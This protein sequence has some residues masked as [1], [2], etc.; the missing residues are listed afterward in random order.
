MNLEIDGEKLIVPLCSCGRCIVKRERT[1]LNPLFPYNKKLGSTYLK[2]YDQKESLLSP[3]YFNRSKRNCFD[4][5]YKEHLPAGL[6]SRMKYDFKPFKIVLE[7]NKSPVKNLESIPFWGKSSYN[8]FFPN[9]GSPT[10]G[11]TEKV[12]LPRI[13]VPLRG[14]SNYLDNY[15]RYED[16]VYKNRDP[17]I[18][19]KASINFKGQ[20]SPDTTLRDTYKP[21]DYSQKH[22]FSP[23]KVKKAEKEKTALIPANYSNDNFKSTYE[24]FFSEKPK[25]CELATYLKVRGLKN[26]EL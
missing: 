7:E 1:T 14:K 13:A 11:N 20:L 5:S 22:Y 9:Y 24:N 23:D 8:S 2:D 19:Q 21:F 17:M 16:E 12:I 6:M 10:N 3:K 18:V 26:L 25:S 15:K 4:G